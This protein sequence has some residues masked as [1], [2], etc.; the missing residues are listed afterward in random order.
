M[1]HPIHSAT[2]AGSSAKRSAGW[3]MPR[4]I[5]EP[6]RNAGL[7]WIGRSERRPDNRRAQAHAQRRDRAETKPAA[8]DDEHGDHGHDLLVHV[9]DGAHDCEAATDERDD[10]IRLPE[11]AHERRNEACERTRAVD[12]GDGTSYE[13]NGQDDVGAG[14]DP[15]WC[16]GYGP[17]QADRCGR[18]SRV[19]A[20][21]DPLVPCGIDAALVR[22]GR[23]DPRQEDRHRNAAEEEHE[24]V[25][26]PDSQEDGQRI[27]QSKRC[28]A[29][30]RSMPLASWSARGGRAR[31]HCNAMASHGLPV[32]GLQPTANG[33]LR[34]TAY[35]LTS[36][37]S[38]CVTE[39]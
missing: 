24:R 9:L 25:R 28:V 39:P 36:E 37:R 22:A 27:P 18:H 23:Q 5:G 13:Q 19:G 12:E 15:S 2:A 33:R 17:E 29:L 30:R 7:E 31:S 14:H 21:N 4:Q 20:R 8:Q 38:A 6:E 34:P 26:E 10:D 11:P 35:S 16:S 3:L 1:V 32:H